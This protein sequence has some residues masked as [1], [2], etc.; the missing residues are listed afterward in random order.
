MNKA[1]LFVPKNFGITG[2]FKA[3]EVFGS[4]KCMA[5]DINDGSLSLKAYSQEKPHPGTIL[6]ISKP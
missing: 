3:L 5:A 6:V 2:P 1:T 4:G